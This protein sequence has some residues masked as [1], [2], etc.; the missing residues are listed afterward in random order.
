MKDKEQVKG[1]KESDTA[2]MPLPPE[3]MKSAFGKTFPDSKESDWVYKE[4]IGWF[5]PKLE[6]FS[7]KTLVRKCAAS[8]IPGLKTNMVPAIAHEGAIWGFVIPGEADK[9]GWKTCAL[10]G[11]YFHPGDDVLKVFDQE[12]Y[13]VGV[14]K[15]Y[16]ECNSWTPTICTHTKEPYI[17]SNCMILADFGDGIKR[18]VSKYALASSGDFQ[19]CPSCG[20]TKLKTS[21][22]QLD[23][24]L[25]CKSC[26]AADLKVQ[27]I[28]AYNDHVKL[29]KMG[30][31]ME[32]LGAK[33]GTDG[34][35]MATGKKEYLKSTRLFGVEIETEM[36]VKGVKSIG[37]LRGN[38]A[39]E[40]LDTLGSEFVYCKEDGTLL[41]NGKYDG[42][43][44]HN[45]SSGGEFYAGIEVVSCP[46]D[47]ATHEEMW[48]KMEDMKCYKHL[49][50]WDTTTCGC[51]VHVS[52]AS[53]TSLQIGR[54]LRAVNHPEWAKFIHKIAGRGSDQFCRYYDKQLTDALH[55]ERVVSP[56]ESSSYNRSRRVAVNLANENTIEFR[57]FRGTVNPRHI[58]RNIEF[59]DAICDFCYPCAR[60]FKEIDDYKYFI[61]F[62]SRNRKR[63]PHLAAWLA[64][65][66]MI[67]M[68]KVGAGA[69]PSKF[70]IKPDSVEEPDSDG[71]AR[72][73]KNKS[74]LVDELAECSQDA[75]IL[76]KKK[77]LNPAYQTPLTNY[78]ES[79]GT[80]KYFE[81]V[82]FKT[83]CGNLIP[84]ADSLVGPSAGNSNG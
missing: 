61:I 15:K 45:G 77:K 26:H 38:V 51:H 30:K 62:V 48:P 54:I 53:L 81:D 73:A 29:A 63:Y 64:Y 20:A 71:S 55:P 56:D 72:P 6:Q 11:A 42:A 12:H 57:I 58:L 9:A 40:F 75:A 41:M 32:R 34:L 19:N 84:T 70:T 82:T 47:R 37:F 24:V 79:I 21:L 17:G 4:Y 46:A 80:P 69:D 31:T 52:R 50:A 36:D 18:L 10:S 68:K 35:W 1:L 76:T 74:P 33:K 2:K 65:Q 66:R 43:K 8:E 59:C 25:K 39:L 60:S 5:C 14:H 7:I 44:G 23:G 3:K 27:Y 78:L 83:D 28:H 22:I 16:A 67:T 13:E 49:R